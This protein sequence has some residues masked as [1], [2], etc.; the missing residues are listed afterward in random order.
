[1]AKKKINITN[2]IGKSNTNIL[3]A[4]KGAALIQDLGTLLESTND[5]NTNKQYISISLISNNPFQPRIEIKQ[6][7][8]KELANS[9][10]KDGLIQPIIVQKF[11][12]KYI[13][14]A[15][16]RRVAAYKLLKKND[17][18]AHVI[19]TEFTNTTVNN[20]L[21]FTTAAI[22]NIQREN[23]HPIEIALSCQEAINK[24]I[25]HSIVEISKTLNK[26]KSYLSKIMSVLKLNQVIIDDLLKNKSV[27]DIEVLYELQ[28]IKNAEQQIKL[29]YE[30]KNK[31]ITREDIRYAVKAQKT[32]V[33]IAPIRFKS[34]SKKLELF[35]DLTQ[36]EEKVAKKLQKNL[37]DLLTDYQ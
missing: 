3:N 28:K 2:S 23:L 7:Q 34:N 16:H 25:F 37:E 22:E 35:V 18:W 9:I 10:N 27:K 26:S 29:F 12:D 32:T 36:F 6:E 4:G 21:L 31:N 33:M 20:R 1:M 13:V 19:E 24:K 15:G 30:Y 5:S 14:I 11:E 17:I 8:L